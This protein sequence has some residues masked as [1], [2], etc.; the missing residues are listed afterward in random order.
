MTFKNKQ[1]ITMII[2]SKKDTVYPT[3]KISSE[4]TK[5]VI[6]QSIETISLGV[7]VKYLSI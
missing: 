6:K 7:D 3:R 1:N 5:G 2:G 4:E